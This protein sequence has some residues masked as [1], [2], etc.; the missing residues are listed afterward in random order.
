MKMRNRSKGVGEKELWRDELLPSSQAETHYRGSLPSVLPITA[1][2]N[3][4]LHYS[5]ISA[6]YQPRGPKGLASTVGWE[7]VSSAAICGDRRTYWKSKQEQ[8]E[9]EEARSHDS[10]Q[11]PL[12]PG[13]PALWKERVERGELVHSCTTY[14]HPLQHIHVLLYMAEPYVCGNR[15]TVQASTWDFHHNE[16][17]DPQAVSRAF[18]NGWITQSKR[19]RGI[20]EKKCVNKRQ[21]QKNQH[22]RKILTPRCEKN[23]QEEAG[24]LARTPG[25]DSHQLPTCLHCP[26]LPS[27]Q[28]L[29]STL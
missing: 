14:T 5:P 23:T 7:N 22:C 18:S 17:P 11:A 25:E 13:I 29:L 10:G 4:L 8:E 19:D 27:E 6:P 28:G 21:G 20:T 24:R 3:I 16:L 9:G 2:S 12:W 15:Y 1:Q 26:P